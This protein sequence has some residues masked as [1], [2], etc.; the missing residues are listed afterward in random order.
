MPPEALACTTMHVRIFQY[1]RIFFFPDQMRSDYSQ[2][3]PGTATTT[4]TSATTSG[5]AKTT[6]TSSGTT[7]T[8]TSTTTSTSSTATPPADDPYTGYTVYLSPY[9]AAEIAAAV[10]TITDSSL[11]EKAAQVA[12]VPTF[13]WSVSQAIFA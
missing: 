6:S 7:K 3:L 12:K 4:A 2:C 5:T 10:A 1:S 11:A 8:S 9:Y 13:T